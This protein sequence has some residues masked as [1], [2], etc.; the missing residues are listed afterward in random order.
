MTKVGAAYT[1]TIYTRDRELWAMVVQ[2]AEER[3]VSVSALIERA[4]IE[5]LLPAND[6]D[7]KLAKI[8]EI[9]R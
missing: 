4:L 2:V 3:Q 1:K 8:R 9:L 6:A 7:Q 5:Y